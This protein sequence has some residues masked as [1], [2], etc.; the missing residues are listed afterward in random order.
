MMT[1]RASGHV[2]FPKTGWLDFRGGLWDN[3]LNKTNGG[4]DAQT[5]AGEAP[6][7]RQLDLVPLCGL[8]AVLQ[9]PL[10][11]GYHEKKQDYLHEG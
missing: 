5:L 3:G 11:G 1:F 7:N 6:D 10:T 9:T 4:A 8:V 2:H